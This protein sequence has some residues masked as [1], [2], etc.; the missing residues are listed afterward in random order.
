MPSPTSADRHATS[1]P[2]E[3][4]REPTAR[5]SRSTLVPDTQL[6]SPRARSR[7]GHFAEAKAAERTELIAALEARKARE[8]EA[9]EDHAAR[10]LEVGT[11]HAAHTARA[12]AMWA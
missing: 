6:G 5:V 10:E 4:H 2:M 9:F 12:C 7:I 3:R 11:P 1:Q 8:M